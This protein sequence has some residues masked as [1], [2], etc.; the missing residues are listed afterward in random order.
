MSSNSSVLRSRIAM[1]A[2]VG[3]TGA[4]LAGSPLAASAA[5]TVVDYTSTN[6]ADYP[7]LMHT[8]GGGGTDW[9]PWLDS[10]A[11]M[12]APWVTGDKNWHG[13]DGWAAH[14]WA[15]QDDGSGTNGALWVQKAQAGAASSGIQVA[16]VANG[17]SLISSANKVITIKVKAADANVPVEATLTDTFGGN[18]LKAVATATTADAYNTL[19]FNFASPTSGTYISNYSYT[20]LSLVMD[21]E[22]AI[23]GNSHEDW[24]NGGAS[25]TVSKAYILDDLTYEVITG[26]DTPPGP[27]VPH[28]LTFE[29]ADTLG[30]LAAGSASDAKWAG[31]FGSGGS[32]IVTPA[33]SLK[34]T[35]KALEFN[36]V[37]GDAWTGL[38]LVAAPAGE[39]ITSSLYKTIKFDYYSPISTLTP[40]SIKLIASDNSAV[41]AA[42]KAK[43]GWQTFS[44][45]MSTLSGANGV[46]SA[47][48]N[49]TQ[50]AF[51]PYWADADILP[52]GVTNP[53]TPMLSKKFYI[54]NV[55]F[56]GFA[57]P[58]KV[59]TPT[60]SGTA[61][62][63]RVLTA[64][65]VTFA[66]N[67]ITRG[68]KWYRCSVQGKTAKST[69]PASSDKCS[70]IS[71]AT[72][73]TYTLTTSDKGKYIRV[74]LTATTAAGTVYALTTS[75]S[76]VG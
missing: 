53:V 19:S 7:V 67:R 49:Y 24:G 11:G 39:V 4:L 62:V 56:N 5:P 23:A 38:N 69:A 16:K 70:T 58:T 64:A 27:D 74:A 6:A 72:A 26:A 22:N 17:S 54:D 76:K 43:K 18:V 63:G 51:F 55:A 25:A 71:G 61:K 41:R 2:T 28:L 21:P 36:K 57:L 52:A 59:G 8:G 35:G 37:G 66:G 9:A 68:F 65:G 15:V 40:V 32:G 47:D 29:T 20:T 1:M 33:G 42:F 50:L 10:E 13:R 12:N 44:I 30:S 34:H 31:S 46:W 14:N 73:A 3:I 45:D 48:K 60:K 75:T